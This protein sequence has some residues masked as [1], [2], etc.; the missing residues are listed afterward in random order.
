MRGSLS[1]GEPY[2]FIHQGSN[3]KTVEAICENL[4]EPHIVP[5]LALIIEPVYPVNGCTFV[6]TTEQEEIFWVLDLHTRNSQKCFPMFVSPQL[7]SFKIICSLCK[8]AIIT[9]YARSK[10][11]VSRLCF[12]LST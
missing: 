3:R 9:L 1:T 10:H 6:I 11:I 12:P 5:P 8:G 2:L 4:P 7:S